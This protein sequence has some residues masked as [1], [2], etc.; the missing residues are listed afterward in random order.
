MN[1]TQS[2]FQDS[3]CLRPSSFQRTLTR[4]ATITGP[5]LF[6]GVDCKLVL[7]PAGENTGIRFCRVDLPGKPTVAA[8]VE[9]VTS[10]TRRTVLSAN[11]ATVETT[12]H[13]M[14]ALAGLQV[15]NCLIELNAPEVPAVDGSCLPFCEVILDAGISDQSVARALY[16]VPEAHAAAGEGGERLEITPLFGNELAICY[17]L[18][19]GCDSAVPG[20]AFS[21]TVTPE[22]FLNEIA[23]ARTF[24]LEKEVEA[25]R[26]MGFGRHLTEADIVV[27]AGDGTIPGNSLRWPDEPVRHKILDCIGDLALCGF[28]FAG[29]IIARRSGH[30]LNHVMASI[31]SMMSGRGILRRA[32]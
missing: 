29:Q 18:D 15:D 6:H 30:K 11:G 10:A 32:A 8:R 19:Y 17:Q 31:V 2:A 4:S 12:E 23:A 24:V 7:H 1:Q 28:P 13:L 25:L 22:A 27:F 14:A 20:G 9:N 3:D 16:Q 26:Q 5:G 21:L